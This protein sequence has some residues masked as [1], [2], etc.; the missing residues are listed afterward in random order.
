[1]SKYNVSAVTI[2]N[3]I[4]TTDF[5]AKADSQKAFLADKIVVESFPVVAW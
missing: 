3:G 1:M 5:Y 2:D 4:I